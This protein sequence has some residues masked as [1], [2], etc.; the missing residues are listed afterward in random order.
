VPGAPIAAADL[1][2]VGADRRQWRAWLRRNHAKRTEV[3]L[4][5]WRAASGRPRIAYSAAVEEALCYGWIDS[6]Q[7][8]LDADRVAQRFSPRRPGS[9]LSEMNR[10]RVRRLLAQR[11]MTK[12]GL[13]A[14]AGSFD[15]Q[16]KEAPLRLPP[17]VR[18]ALR[19]EPAAWRNFQ[20]APESYRRLRI[21]YIEAGRRHGP[22]QVAK[23]IRNLVAKSAAGKRFGTDPQ[24]R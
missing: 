9:A 20:A 1:L 12:A 13:A 2:D 7:K 22:E 6:Q 15:P 23:R 21:A 24:M 18:A 10:Q 16:G 8:G 17:D 5:Y 19:A 3:W 11:R 4:V 14:I